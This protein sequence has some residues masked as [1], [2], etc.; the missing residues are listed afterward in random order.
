MI[1]NLEE[2]PYITK[3]NEHQ[4]FNKKNFLMA[5]VKYIT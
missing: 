4:N 5:F 1:N 2:I 3:Q